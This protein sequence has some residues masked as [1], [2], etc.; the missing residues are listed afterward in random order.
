MATVE[1]TNEESIFGGPY[2]TDDDGDLLIRVTIDKKEYFV[3]VSCA[4]VFHSGEIFS[5]TP[6]GAG[7]TF[8]VTI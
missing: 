4:E 8:K 3:S 6:I 7:A 2:F 5:L 1:L